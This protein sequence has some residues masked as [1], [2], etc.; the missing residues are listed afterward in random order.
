MGWTLVHDRNGDGWAREDGLF[1]ARVNCWN[2]STRLEQAW[3]VMDKVSKE[4]EWRFIISSAPHW[5]QYEVTAKNSFG[6]SVDTFACG[7][8]APLAITLAILYAL[9]MYGDF[10]TQ[11]DNGCDN[12]DE[13]PLRLD[14]SGYQICARCRGVE[15][16]RP[17]TKPYA[18]P[19][20]KDVMLSKVLF[21]AAYPECRMNAIIHGYKYLEFNTMVFATSVTVP[22][23]KNAVCMYDECAGRFD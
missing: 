12:E 8:T 16:P 3:Q 4:R 9:R 1:G 15:P 7:E 19:S 22:E 17:T 10:M 5:K 21:P 2:P 18:T 23:F 14:K 6:S 13:L 20:K 11:C